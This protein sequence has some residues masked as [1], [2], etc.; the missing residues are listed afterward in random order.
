MQQQKTFWTPQETAD[1][2]LSRSTLVPVRSMPS[3]LP[4]FQS[5]T[6]WLLVMVSMT[7]K[8]NYKLTHLLRAWVQHCVKNI[9]IWARKLS[10]IQDCAAKR[11]GKY[12]R[13]NLQRERLKYW[14][15]LNMLFVLLCLSSNLPSLQSIQNSRDKNIKIDVC[16]FRTV[17]HC[18]VLWHCSPDFDACVWFFVTQQSD[19]SLGLCLKYIYLNSATLTNN[20]LNKG[21]QIN[22]AR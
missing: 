10:Q 7:T 20:W 17:D 2:W 1:M 19:I 15:F 5:Q 13:R 8:L 14:D 9:Y 21:A 18:F 4:R 22:L 16:D 6:P 11:K 3:V 12:I